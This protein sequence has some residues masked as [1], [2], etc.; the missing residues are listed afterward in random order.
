MNEKERIYDMLIMEANMTDLIQLVT[1]IEKEFGTNTYGIIEPSCME[2]DGM[3]EIRV[4]GVFWSCYVYEEELKEELRTLIQG[5]AMAEPVF[6]SV[7]ADTIGYFSKEQCDE[8]NNA[9]LKLPKG[10]VRKYFVE[11]CLED[12]RSDDRTVSDQGLFEEWLDEHTNDDTM[13]LVEFLRKQGV[14]IAVVLIYEDH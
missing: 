10:I 12:F 13:D 1:N 6:V 4:G 3:Y 9:I 2:T 14:N 8:D 5:F 11:R 7:Y